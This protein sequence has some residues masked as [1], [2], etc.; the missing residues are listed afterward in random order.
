MTHDEDADNTLYPGF[1][2]M[3]REIN[4]PGD[5]VWRE[6]VEQYLDLRQFMQYV[7]I[8]VYL[9][10]WDGM[11]GNWGMNNFFIYNP[12]G[13]LKHTLIPWDRDH[14]IL[15]TTGDMSIFQRVFE[16]V[17]FSRAWA[18]DDL[19]A[20]YLEALKQCAQRALQDD[21]F[22]AEVAH[23]ASLISGPVFEDPKKQFSNADFDTEVQAIM[24]FAQV[25]P[26]FVLQSVA[27]ALA[28]GQ[29]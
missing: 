13:G 6:R 28:G 22:S 1:R 23:T 15:Q 14:A 24:T 12:A 20:A 21:W 16:N 27:A 26:G 3:F 17:I 5:A 2:D 9:S 18:Y 11:T 19:R 29:D 4:G 8:E 10:E 7:A 25:R